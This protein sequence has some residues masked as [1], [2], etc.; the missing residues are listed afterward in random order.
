MYYVN[1]ARNFYWLFWHTCS[2]P[3]S[4]SLYHQLQDRNLILIGRGKWILCPCQCFYQF[5]IIWWCGPVFITSSTLLISPPPAWSLVFK[6]I[7]ST[8]HRTKAAA[9]AYLYPHHIHSVMKP[10]IHLRVTTARNR[11]MKLDCTM[12]SVWCVPPH[13]VHNN[14]HD[15][16]KVATVCDGGID[17]HVSNRP[18]PQPKVSRRFH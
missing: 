3:P 1:V 6:G 13:F 9:I 5:Q 8:S 18:P 10:R 7:E 2:H 16:E 12:Q 14:Y 17:H 15:F 4:F 11:R